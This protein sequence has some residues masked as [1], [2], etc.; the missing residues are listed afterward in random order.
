MDICA[1]C[2]QSILEQDKVT[3]RRRDGSSVTLCRTCVAELKAG[4]KQSSASPEPAEATAVN[5]TSTSKSVRPTSSQKS[6]D[7]WYKTIGIGILGIVLT[8]I[9][10]NMLNDLETG[11]VSSVRVWWPVAVLYRMFGFWGGIACPGLVALFIL[12]VGVKQ[13]IDQDKAV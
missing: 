13:L 10:A 3:V 1:R 11:A 2:N 6:E 12:G 8:F 9:I 5:P 4:R 7:K